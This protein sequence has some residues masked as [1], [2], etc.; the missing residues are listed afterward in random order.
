MIRLG[1]CS[2]AFLACGTLEIV[3]NA[4]TAGLDAIE[5]AA[6]AHIRPGDLKTAEETMM[7]T[8]R[9]GMT[10]ASYASLYRAGSEDEGHERFKALLETAH[11]LYAPNLR[12]FAP[13]RPPRGGKMPAD[14]SG[15]LRALGD[16]AAA[17]GITLCLSLG[18][19]TCLDGYPAALALV[20]EAGHPFVKLAWEDLPD[21]PS[22]DA[23]E[24]LESRG[25]DVAL[26]IA[27][28]VDRDGRALGIVEGDADWKRRIAS[29]KGSE[30]DPKMGSFVL[31][32]S[33]SG[34]Q[35]LAAE[36]AA[37]RALVKEI[38]G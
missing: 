22:G 31:I 24:A 25:K 13:P 36:A 8:L 23:T 6:D 26:V 17:R 12:V 11:Y 15:K 30:A 18:R 35:G 20:A 1:L 28:C 29:F 7:A 9:A 21:T 19:H 27:R 4:A 38:G 16:M 3:E 2:G 37:L 14:L 34:A 32:G 33:S 5:W 10:I